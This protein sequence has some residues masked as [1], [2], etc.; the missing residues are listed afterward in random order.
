[1]HMSSGFF[2]LL[3]PGTHKKKDLSENVLFLKHLGLPNH[4]P[5]DLFFLIV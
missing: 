3:S 2:P 4:F 1:M 5:G